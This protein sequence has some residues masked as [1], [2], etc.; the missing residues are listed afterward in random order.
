VDGRQIVKGL[1]A[2]VLMFPDRSLTVDG[3]GEVFGA[4]LTARGETLKKG[5]LRPAMLFTVDKMNT[6]LLAA[7]FPALAS[8]APSGAVSLSVSL[9]E[10]LA[11]EAELRS[12]RLVL[13][14]V[15]LDDLAAVA[16][17]DG[18]S[19]VL[20]G[21]RGKIGRAPLDLSGVVDLKTGA[22]RFDGALKGLSPASVPALAESVTGACDVVLSAQGTTRSPQ[23]TVA[24]SG[25]E[26]RVADVPIR[27]LRLSGTWANDRVS[28][29]ETALRLPGGSVS[30]R[31]SVDLPKGAEPILDIS[32]S[33]TGLDLGKTL[34]SLGTPITGS[35]GGTLK[36]SGPVSDAA[37]EAL[38][39][40]D[41]IGGTS[42]DIRDLHLDFAGTTRNV[43]IREVRVRVNGGSVEGRGKMSFERRGGMA[44]EM[45]VRGIEVR[46]LLSQFGV[47]A[48][49]GGYLDGTLSLV[50]TPWRPELKLKVT[51]PLT[52]KETL[53]DNLAVTVSSPERGRLDFGA[54]GQ[55]GDL[56][57]NVRGRLVRDR[58]G[59]G[60]TYSAEGGPLDLDRLA[61]AKM[62]SM[63]GKYAGSVK[64]SASGRLNGGRGRGSGEGRAQGRGSERRGPQNRELQDQGPQPVDIAITLPSFSTAGIT[65]RDVSL[66]LCLLGDQVTLRDGTARLFDG[67]VSLS[68]DV[69]LPDQQWRASVKIEGLD[70]GQ[71][72]EPFMSQG[73]IAG[74]ADVSVSANGDYGTLMMVFARGD[75]KSGSGY[76]HE[77]SALDAV[78]KD[79]RL[80]FEEIRGS[81]FWDG[82]DLWLN[83]GSQAT[84]PPG[85][86]L[87]R[88]FALNGSLGIPGTGLGLM[89][90]G[91]FDVQALNTVLGALKSAFQYMTG[92][93][94]GGGSL[95][96]SLLRGV[97]AKVVGYTEHDFQD[98]TFQLKGSWQALQ[99]LNLKISK[100][101]EGY[102]PLSG[103]NDNPAPEGKDAER[104][105]QINLRI[106]TGPGSTEDGE[107]T[108]NQI[109]KQIL[110][111]LI[112]F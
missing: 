36:V 16:R 20:D 89:C 87:Y 29:P 90:Q 99:L 17:Y 65:M 59:G 9:D 58:E 51:S 34:S 95:G 105:F 23:V 70:L 10:R 15:R 103:M 53:V 14:G 11:A 5:D 19:V 111:N 39:T 25:E 45:K 72:A 71:A 112:K 41:R 31:G 54:D 1:R 85:A 37:L 43:E 49:M 18:R 78:T 75:F 35:V 104:K 22:L 3:S 48:G 76:I 55:M 57:L 8:L 21:L 12:A 73:A 92:T 50:G 81:F 108:E 24:I 42:M 46:S 27:G 84:A 97:A 30:F 101:L 44:V 40:S 67:A 52:I 47:D 82:K 80:P 69:N 33:L 96:G 86:P 6:A 110:D 88:Y 66:P 64:V 102:L 100:S 38:V 4:K 60:W 56:L 2:E 79:G 94:S 7:A 77:F 32:G 109:K 106:P 13:G 74:S 91:R 28:I 83:P 93:L 98:V 107:D 61:T 62:P 68:A 63:K 26:N